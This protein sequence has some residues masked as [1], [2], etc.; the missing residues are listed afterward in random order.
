MQTT[1]LN[2]EIIERIKEESARFQLLN[3]EVSKVIV[4]NEQTINFIMIAILCDGHILLEGVP[5]VAKRPPL[6]LLPK[7][8]ASHLNVFNLHPIYYRQIL[9]EL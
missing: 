4:G 3:S 6:K 5:G 2:N 1:S 9:S 7:H 8:S